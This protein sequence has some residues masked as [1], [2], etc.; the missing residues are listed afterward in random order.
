MRTAL[1]IALGIA[2]FAIGAGGVI[3]A[4]SLLVFEVMSQ[5][6][7]TAALGALFLWFAFLLLRQVRWH[8]G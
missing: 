5:A 8:E 4:I 6:A 2:C 1:K 3:F 7:V